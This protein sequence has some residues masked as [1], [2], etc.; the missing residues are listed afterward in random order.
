MFLP[1]LGILSLD[2]VF[3]RIVGDAG[4]PASFPFPARVE[5]VSGA[6]ATLIVRDGK[7]SSQ[8]VSAFASAAR[9]LE[10]KGAFGLTSTCGFLISSQAEIAAT[11][12]I[13]VMLS[14]LSLLPLLQVLFN[15]AE[16]GVMTASK[17]SL[18]PISLSAAGADTAR[19]RLQGMED[20]AIF[21]E[22][23]LAQ[24][25]MQA[26][27]FERDK[28]AEAVVRQSRHLVDEHP[29]IGCILLECGNLPPYADEIR[30]ATGKPV[31]SILDGA[32]LMHHA[33]ATDG[34]DLSQ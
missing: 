13:P 16:I 33:A 2:T 5:V 34:S 32:A 27:A 30:A 18:G 10:H 20:E 4:N 29:E 1:F 9:S 31:Y 14:G 24:R 25:G 28:M 3:P 23:F 11:V 6:D 17:R 26:R 19:L 21:R 15:G 22:C 12:K 8:L 7:P